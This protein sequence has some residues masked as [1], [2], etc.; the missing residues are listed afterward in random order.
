V[1][2]G[3]EGGG[4]A[5]SALIWRGRMKM[6]LR[7]GGVRA[8]AARTPWALMLTLCLVLV[9][10]VAWL[11]AADGASPVEAGG[12][13]R[14]RFDMKGDMKKREGKEGEGRSKRARP[15]GGDGSDGARGPKGP[16]A[17]DGVPDFREGRRGKER[18]GK[19]KG[20]SGKSMYDRRYRKV[21]QECEE[22]PDNKLQ[23]WASKTT[24]KCDAGPMERENCVLRCTSATCYDRLYDGNALEEGEI[25]AERNRQFRAC[26]R[27]EARAAPS[28]PR[29]DEL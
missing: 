20:A 17:K 9:A 26:W 15:D 1:G 6:A 4:E 23:E 24:G 13:G 25:N 19:G 12:E 2:W 27:D 5:E 28:S 22:L 18:Q 10:L 7:S 3:G 8:R 14:K 29:G 16:K 11:P 21:R